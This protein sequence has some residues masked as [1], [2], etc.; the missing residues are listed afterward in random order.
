M[1]IWISTRKIIRKIHLAVDGWIGILY[2]RQPSLARLSAQP[3]EHLK[4]DEFTDFIYSQKTHFKR[5]RVLPNYRNQS[6]ATCDLKVYQDSLIYTFIL[7]NFP[8][9]SRLLEIGGG[10]SRVISALKKQYEIW[11]LDKLEGVGFG[12][13]ELW[14][15]AGFRFVQDYIGTFSSELPND[16]FD[17][18]FSI[19]TLEHLP[20]DQANVD[21]VLADIHRLLKPG[22]FSLHCIDGLLYQKYYYVHPIVSAAYDQSLV[23]YSKIDFDTLFFDDD[24][25]L[26]PSYAFYSR[27]YPLVKESIKTFGHPFSVNLLWQKS[28]VG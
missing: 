21:A 24:L 19:S 5:F 27:W 25:W 20:T 1:T 22:G 13:K 10:E 7:D 12:P 11:N 9:G 18:V 4:V 8:T 26:L 23:S 16:Y 6:P 2:T 28:N 15:Q 17:L 3:H 14:T